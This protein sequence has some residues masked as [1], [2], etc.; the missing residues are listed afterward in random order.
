M[1]L[2]RL[3]AVWMTT[4][5]H[6]PSV[7]WHCWLG[8]YQTCKNIVPEMTYTVSSLTLSLTQ[9]ITTHDTFWLTVAT[10]RSPSHCPQ[11]PFGYC[12]VF[13]FLVL[14]RKSVSCLCRRYRG[15]SPTIVRA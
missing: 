1:S 12:E 15:G 2:V 4:G 7:L 14:L 9:S 6:P 5:N 8:Q 3:R 10:D 13:F 11:V